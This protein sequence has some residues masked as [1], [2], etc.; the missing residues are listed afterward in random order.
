MLF[1]CIYNKSNKIIYKSYFIHAR[2]HTHTHTCAR[3]HNIEN[4]QLQ[5]FCYG[6]YKISNNR[7]FTWKIDLI[8]DF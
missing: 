1:M 5:N 8:D 6:F 3:V 2:T 7:F 4:L